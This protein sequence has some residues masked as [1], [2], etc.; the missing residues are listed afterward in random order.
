MRDH[1]S[2]LFHYGQTKKP[3]WDLSELFVKNLSRPSQLTVLLR[4]VGRRYGITGCF[5]T[6]SRSFLLAKAGIPYH[7]WS[8]GSDLDVL[9]FDRICPVCCSAVQRAVHFF[10]VRFLFGRDMKR[11]LEGAA[12]IMIAPY[13]KRGLEMLSVKK[14]QFFLPH[15]LGVSCDFEALRKEKEHSCRML[16]LELEVDEFFFSSVRHVW[17]K[18]NARLADNKGNDVAIRAFSSYLERTKNKRSK[19]VFVDK[20]YDVAASKKLIE[21]LG[22]RDRVVWVG[23]VPRDKLADYYKGAKLCFGQ[24]GNPVLTNAALEPLSFA[25]PCVSYYGGEKTT[26]P[27]YSTLPPVYNSKNIQEIVVFM[28]KLE[29]NRN[30]EENLCKG[31]WDWVR[32]YC[33]EESFTDAFVRELS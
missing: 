7:Y 10:S 24:F 30:F 16:C 8:Y 6:G 4:D 1:D 14:E 27:F 23:Q 3:S 13:Q 31:S 15:V 12:K 9:Y 29:Q 20:G 26:V 33:S 2:A 19:L 21:T 32:D 17:A 5:A 11:T 25:T 28:H 22:L 18:D